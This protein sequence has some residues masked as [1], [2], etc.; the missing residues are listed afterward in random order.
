[1]SFTNV[2][3]YYAKV[4]YWSNT[5]SARHTSG[6]LAMQLHGTDYQG[7]SEDNSCFVNWAPC[8]GRKELVL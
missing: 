7:D 8:R 3:N 5:G 4:L 1:M 6:H 2:D